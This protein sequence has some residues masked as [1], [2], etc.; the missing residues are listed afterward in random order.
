MS[1][2]DQQSAVANED[3]ISIATIRKWKMRN[4]CFAL[5]WHRDQDVSETTDEDMRVSRGLKK[6]RDRLSREMSSLVSHLPFQL[7]HVLKTP[8]WDVFRFVSAAFC[9]KAEHQGVQLA[10]LLSCWIISNWCWIDGKT[11]L[12]TNECLAMGL[13]TSQYGDISACSV[14]KS[15]L[16]NETP[17]LV[18]QQ[19]HLGKGKY[20]HRTFTW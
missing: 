3:N 1:E 18:P 11:R 15:H 10:S 16:M 5:K 4:V 6:K 19:G 7:R 9:M 17:L 13:S 2:A 20:Y 8:Q 12:L 14:I